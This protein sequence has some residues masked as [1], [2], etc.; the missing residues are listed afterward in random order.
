MTIQLDSKDSWKS[1]CNHNF[2]YHVQKDEYTELQCTICD[3][4]EPSSQKF[5]CP[6]LARLPTNFGIA[7]QTI[8]RMFDWINMLLCPTTFME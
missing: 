1:N 8:S 3:K 5:I 6:K 4:I 2:T 7:Y